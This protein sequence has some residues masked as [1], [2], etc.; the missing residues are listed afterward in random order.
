MTQLLQINKSGDRLFF[1]TFQAGQVGMLDVSEPEHPL[2]QAPARDRDEVGVPGSAR[3]A[4]VTSR[5][6]HSS[7]EQRG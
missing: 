6:R 1:G 2:Q 3:A 4:A 5:S 7:H